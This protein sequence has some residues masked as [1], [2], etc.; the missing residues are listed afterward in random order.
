MKI[1]LICILALGAFAATGVDL[2]TLSTQENFQCMIEQYGISF[3][4]MRGYRS[5]GAVDPNVKINLQRAQDAGIYFT[6]VYLFPCRSKSPVDQANELI[7]HLADTFYGYIYVDVETNN[8]PGCGW[9]DYSFDSNCQFIEDLVNQIVKRGK[10]PGIY[11]SGYMWKQILGSV[12]ACQKF[13]QYP[14]W[15]PHY[16]KVASFS[17]FTEFGGWTKPNM[18]Q[19]QGTTTICNTGVDFNWYPQC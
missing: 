13:S 19:Y 12:T 9:G 17:D 11:A 2:S 10:S 3:L 4:I 14:I 16:D 6:D 1:V 18:K 8:S 15:Y 7:D 5:Y